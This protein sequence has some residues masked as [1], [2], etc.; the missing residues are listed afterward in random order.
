MSHGAK[1]PARPTSVS[2]P[3]SIFVYGC[4]AGLLGVAAMT[5]TEKIEQY[6]TGRPSSLVPGKTLSALVGSGIPRD[7]APGMW[8]TNMAMHYG[9]G[10]L[11]A[12]IRAFMSHH[13]V[14]G[15][16]ADFIFTGVRLSID[17]TL[18]NWTGVGALP[19]T[20]PVNEQIIDILHKAV[21]ALVTGWFT[22]RWIR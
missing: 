19:W 8:T 9:Q 2:S 10:A 18:E 12:V 17:Q 7:D 14:R 4:G 16:F 6:F 22:D 21:F 20:W 15:P 5:A 1:G 11:A 13:G 3:V